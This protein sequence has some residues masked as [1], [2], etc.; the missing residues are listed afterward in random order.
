[1]PFSTDFIQGLIPV[2]PLRQTAD[3]GGAFPAPPIPARESRVKKSDRINPA[4]R[5]TRR[6]G[7]T[8]AAGAA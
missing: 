4:N 1:M 5:P 7:A 2:T 8:E 6:R 3:V